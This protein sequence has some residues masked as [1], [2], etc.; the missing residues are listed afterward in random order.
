MP[1]PLLKQ[2]QGLPMCHGLSAAQ[3]EELVAIAEE[4]S[5]KKGVT[6]FK[7]GEP[8]DVMLVVL[9]GKVDVT[10]REAVLA[11][12]EAG[13]VLGEM[14]LLGGDVRSATAIAA[15]DLKYLAISNG[16]FQ[17]LLGKENVAALKV[18][19]NLAQVMS[20]RLALI[21]EKLVDSLGKTKKKEEL[22]DFGRILNHWSF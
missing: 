17:K 13:S 18:V 12:L 2:L 10:K 11:T 5:V 20:K 7:E 14:S 8:G 16:P 6:L 21:N 15:T 19:R 3:V 4:K 22:A 1:T 9:E